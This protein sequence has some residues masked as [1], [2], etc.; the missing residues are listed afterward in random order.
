[1]ESFDPLG[2]F[3][4][5]TFGASLFL[6]GL[7]DPD[8]IIGALRLKDFHAMRVIAVFVVI[9]MVGTWV[10]SLAGQAH[11]NVKPAYLLAALIGGGLL[12]AGFG[13]TGYCPGTG[14]ACAAAGRVDALVSMAGMFLGA[15]AY[16][17]V[18]PQ[19]V[20]AIE[21]IG[22]YGTVTLP[23]WTQTPAGNWVGPIAIVTALVLWLT[24]PR[25][26]GTPAGQT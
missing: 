14:L 26:G 24:R 16:I 6:A 25:R 19:V 18:Y 2:F 11:F 1:M 23:Q 9:G 21:S 7:A 8:K 20:P 3:V 22:N 13:L 10:L 4:G 12:G 15:M 17:L 5:V